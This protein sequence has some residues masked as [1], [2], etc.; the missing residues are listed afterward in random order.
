MT[1]ERGVSVQMKGTVV[2]IWINTLHK[3][4]KKEEIEAI[5]REAS[6]DPNKA[7]SPMEDISD[8]TVKEIISKIAG[9][10][11][12]SQEKLWYELGKDNIHT[13]YEMYPIFFKKSNMFSFLSS[14]N[15]IHQVVKR[16]IAG[17]KPAILNMEI[18]GNNTA[19]LTYLSQRNMYDYFLGLLEGIKCFFKEKVDIKV[20]EKINGKM[21]VELQF[22]YQLRDDRTFRFSRLFTLGFLKKQS[23][24][25]LAFTLL[26]GLP[27][28]Y[29]LDNAML[30]TV[31][32]A[33][34]AGLASFML[35]R[36]IGLIK[37]EIE[38]LKQKN[39]VSARH[40]NSG[41]EYEEIFNELIAYKMAFSEG[42]ID[43]SSM[44]GEMKSFS[45]DLLA[46]TKIL[47]QNGN[48][49]KGFIEDL[50]QMTSEQSDLM[51][52]NVT[53]L[54]QNAENINALSG[55]EINNKTEIEKAI[56]TTSDSF[57]KLK[58]TTDHLRAMKDKFEI[59]KEN[60]EKLN[61]KGSETEEIASFVSEIAFQTNLLAL[62]ASI[63][64]ARAGELGQGFAV[65]A[66]EVRKLAQNSE[67][68][69]VRIKEN[70]FSL[71]QDI[72]TMTDDI[73]V[74]NK[75]LDKEVNSIQT[76]MDNAQK[77]KEEMDIVVVEMSGT[78][79]KLEKQA[80][81]LTEIVDK[82][83]GLNQS[84]AENAEA[85]KSASS[86]VNNCS[87]EIEKMTADIRNFEAMT[88]EFNNMLSE[89]KM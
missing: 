65:V 24:K 2:K 78:A 34:Y 26:L 71:L 29:F 54:T 17:S 44:T 49:L 1:L 18:V 41:D 31:L 88:G 56:Q 19:T 59:L 36:P 67:Q 12:I 37:E 6:F 35:A 79:E 51:A 64:A 53:L 80:Y 43:L 60:S 76:A 68:A 89:Y 87:H 55:Q 45:A 69:A 73:N 48:D 5:L 15:D 30:S 39:Y 14:L 25:V 83:K 85:A 72:Q 86:K 23:W 74:Q 63:E 58:D 4:Y 3:M 33:G 9:R 27:T 57:A 21:I 66:E 13:F 40:I 62:N 8:Q 75:I 10:Y 42:F 16:R 70:I 7:I 22:A 20:L 82:M 46:I 84:S 81:H 11:Q 28:A 32:T 50:Y 52:S 61:R 77:A 47:Q 38:R